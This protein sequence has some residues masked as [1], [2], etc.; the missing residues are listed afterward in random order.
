MNDRNR[1][2]R[3]SLLLPALASL[4]GVIFCSSCMVGPNYKRPA[5][6]VPQGYKEPLTQGIQDQ[7]WKQAQ[8]S[9]AA[10]KGK[11]WEMYNDPAL[12]ALEE[13]VAISNQN[14]LAYEAQYRE[15]RDL[16]RIARANLFP[17]VSVGPSI[18]NSRSSANLYGGNNA[19]LNNLVQQRTVYSLPFSV[20]YQPDIWGSIRRSIN[21]NVDN[22]Q[23]TAA[24]LENARLSYQASLA[25]DYFELHGVDSDEDLLERTVVSYRDYLQLT[26]DRFDAGVATDADV[27]QAETQL[28]TTQAQLKDLATARAQYE[29]AIAVLTGQ[30]PTGVS[31]PR[32]VLTTPPPAI[33]VAVP[34]TLLERRPD[35][36]AAERQMASANEQIGIATAAYYPTIALTGTAGLQSS[37][38][39]TWIQWPSRYW[40][41]GASATETIYDAGRRRAQ[42]SEARNALDVTVANYRQTVLNAFQQVEDNLAA[43]QV[44]AEESVV[45]QQAVSAAQRALDVSTEQYKAGTTDF[46]QVIT[47]QSIALADQRTAVDLLTRRITASVQLIEALGGGWNANTL[48]TRDTIIHGQ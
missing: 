14:I 20:S 37:R 48:P 29:H 17:T 32:V 16:V 42:V 24:Q 2:A 15:A 47:T 22:A 26:K 23:V 44:L 46:L 45:Q 7:T 27:A 3:R 31:I 40:S 33:P 43:L 18:A 9:D 19:A 1:M 12:S 25:V 21:A 41:L 30:P 28:Y 34:S 35:I 13:Q 6:P 4:A 39:T 38:F 36:A 8:P 10:L 11:W 5:A